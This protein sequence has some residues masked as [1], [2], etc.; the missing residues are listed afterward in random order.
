MPTSD[1]DAVAEW[2]GDTSSL[3]ALS[4]LSVLRIAIQL[5]PNAMLP[6]TNRC[7]DRFMRGAGWAVNS[8]LQNL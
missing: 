5:K 8:S 6:R 2:E 3:L 7:F 4:E 1:D